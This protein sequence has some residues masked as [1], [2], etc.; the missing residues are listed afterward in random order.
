MCMMNRRIIAA[1]ACNTA[2][3]DVNNVDRIHRQKSVP[4]G[5]NSV[6]LGNPVAGTL[7]CP[8]AAQT[9]PSRVPAPG[10]AQRLHLVTPDWR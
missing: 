8:I 9:Y 3:P 2:S 4:V 10:G 1:A 5:L 6:C 7:F